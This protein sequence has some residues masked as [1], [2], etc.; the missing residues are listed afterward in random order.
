MF[1]SILVLYIITSGITVILGGKLSLKWLGILSFL[2]LLEHAAVAYVP[3]KIHFD[4][5]FVSDPVL[6]VILGV[7]VLAALI[8][9]FMNF[10][11]HRRQLESKKQRF[12]RPTSMKR[13]LR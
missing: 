8:V 1:G 7:I 2:A 5:D 12:E 13:R 11:L 4:F 6:L 10:L 3:K 9:S